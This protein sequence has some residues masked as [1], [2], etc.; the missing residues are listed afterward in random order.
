MNGKRPNNPEHENLCG[1]SVSVTSNSVDRIANLAKQYWDR[2]S[3]LWQALAGLRPRDGKMSEISPLA[4]GDHRFDAPEWHRHPWYAAVVQSYQFNT[5]LLAG[6]M[7]EADVAPKLQQQ[8]RFLT[9]QLIDAS[10]PA[11]FILTNPEALQLALESNGESLYAGLRNWLTDAT[12]GQIAITDERAFEIGRNVAMSNGEVIFECELM[13]LVQYA[14][15]TQKVARR[16][17]LIVP[18]CVNKFYILD[19]QPQNS[20]VRFAL[21]QGHTVFLVSWRNPQNE[22]QQSTWDDYLE[23]G[24]IQAIEVALAVSGA[25]KVNT[26]GWCIGGT[27]LASALAVLG[28]RGEQPAASMT[29][30]TTLIDFTEPGELGTFVD[31]RTVALAEQTLGK[32]GLLSGKALALVFQSLRAN[33]LL[34]P[35]VVGNYLKGETPEAFDLLYWNSDATNLPGPMYTWLLRHGYHRNELRVPGKLE[36]CGVPFDLGKANVP[37]YVLATERDHLVPWRSAWL[38]TRLLGGDTQFVLAASG[39]IAGVINP[40]AANKRSYWT[41]DDDRASDADDWLAHASTHPGSWWPHWSEWLRGHS[42]KLRAAPK[43]S[44]NAVYAPIE[45][46][47]GRYV[48]T[49]VA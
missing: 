13:Q 32:R 12:R 34:W 38:T 36:V 33:E 37:A 10:S 43:Q 22:L 16:P 44:G 45:P 31:E 5:E 41:G 14:P 42:G 21:E 25:D 4:T 18:P 9:R 26:L 48:K 39:H 23:R 30:L 24:V 1:F 20:F 11:N 29:L 2:Q 19:L 40:P 27:M 7:K 3:M 49:R 6:M 8:L 17:L 46:A 15:L 35:Y 28:A 47:P